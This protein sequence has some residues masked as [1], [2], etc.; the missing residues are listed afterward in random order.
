MRANLQMEKWMEEEQRQGQTE[1]HTME[2]LKITS[3]MVQE[4]II[5]YQQVN[6]RNRSG[7]KANSGTLLS[8]IITKL[9]PNLF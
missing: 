6:L 2:C 8:N 3:N 7:E 4:N 9:T 1:I 5:T